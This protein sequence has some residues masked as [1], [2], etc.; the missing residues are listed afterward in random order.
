MRRRHGINGP[1]TH[2]GLLVVALLLTGVFGILLGGAVL[3][4]PYHRKDWPH[5]IDADGNCRNTRAEVLLR[6][7]PTGTVKF[8]EA[9]E[10]TVDTGEWADP[11]GGGI[12]TQAGEVD[13]DHLVPLK[14]AHEAGGWRWTTARR[15]EYANDL[16]YRYHLLAVGRSANRGK[17]DKGPDQWRPARTEFWCQ[18]AQAWATVKHVWELE[19]TPAERQALREMLRRC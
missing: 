11:Y 8:R 15:Q 4:G 7:A 5:W 2:L 14:N 6:D 9:A 10:C 19:S 1:G 3:R 18:Y 16:A 12:L 13:V 17:G